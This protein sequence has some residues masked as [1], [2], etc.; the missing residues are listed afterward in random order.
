MSETPQRSFARVTEIGRVATRHGFGYLLDRR[1][2]DGA[3]GRRPRAA[4]PRDAR[5]A[6]A[7]V[8]QVRAAALDASGPRPAGHDRRAPEAPGRGDA[9]PDRGRR[10]GRPGGARASTIERAFLDFEE[11]PIAAASIGQVHRATLPNDEEVVVKVQRPTAPR[12]IESDLKLMASAARVVRERV[13]QL[14]FIDANELVD[15]FGRSIRLELDYQQEA[16]NAETFRRNFAGDEPDRRPARLVALHDEPAPDARPPRTASTSATS[17]SM[18]G[19][20]DDRRVARVHDDGR[21]DDDDLP[22]RLL[23]RRP[24]SREH[25]PSRGRAARAR[26][27]R[28]GGAAHGDRHVPPHAAVRRRR[29]R[30]R[31]RAPAAARRARRPV[32]P[33]PRGRAALAARGALLPLLRLTARGHRPDRGDPRRARRSSTG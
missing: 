27:L 13:R 12:Q 26:R 25:P 19:R 8:R 4:A 15:E 28:S 6:R 5:R 17:T 21:V 31:R 1:T 14:D 33:R 9:V 29:D 7:D 24:A 16:R 10:A 11:R 32:S 20:P 3:A 2:A 18:R 22:A 23:P 30:E